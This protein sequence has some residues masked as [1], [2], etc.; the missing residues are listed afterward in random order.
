M[1]LIGP[2]RKHVSHFSLRR[3]AACPL[4][5]AEPIRVT[6]WTPA[7]KEA[8]AAHRQWMG[9]KAYLSIDSIDRCRSGLV[10]AVDM[11]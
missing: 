2:I 1:G 3:R 11:Q 8:A 4:R 7:I 9:R 6:C 10:E 5:R